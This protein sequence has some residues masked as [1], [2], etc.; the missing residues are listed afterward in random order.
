MPGR[1]ARAWKTREPRSKLHGQPVAMPV[2]DRLRLCSHV[3]H[4][5][6]NCL[7]YDDHLMDRL[8]KKRMSS[9]TMLDKGCSVGRALVD[10]HPSYTSWCGPW[11]SGTMRGDS[12]RLQAEG[13]EQ[14][15]LFPSASP[16]LHAVSGAAACSVGCKARVSLLAAF[17]SSSE[18]RR[19]LRGCMEEA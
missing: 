16:G 6:R 3:S 11:M 9:D 2:P 13:F 12:Q 17:A 5:T 18:P 7:H 4:P 15:L 14:M 8:C 10:T 1:C 19:V